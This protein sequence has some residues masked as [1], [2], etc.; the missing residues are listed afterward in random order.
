[1]SLYNF[2][3][4]TG[5]DLVLVHGWG[6]N[7]AVW[8]PLLPAMSAHFRVTVLELP[9][10]GGSTAAAVADLVQAEEAGAYDRVFP[11]FAGLGPAID[12]F[13]DSVRVNAE[14][15]ELRALRRRLQEG[16]RRARGAVLLPHVGRALRGE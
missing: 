15:P 5:P 9:G 8:E 13:F 2:R 1:M 12:A 3:V 10:H 7:A 4:G 16:E 14:D 6:M 11:L